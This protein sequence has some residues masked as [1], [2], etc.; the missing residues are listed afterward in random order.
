MR[1]YDRSVI[2]IDAGIDNGKVVLESEGALSP[3]AKP[4]ISKI[5]DIFRE[6]KPIYVDDENIVFSTWVPPVPGEVF[7]RLISAEISSI[8]RKRVPDQLSIGITSRCP[9]N[10]IHCGAADIIAKTELTVE[11]I[12]GAVSQS[13]EL[14]SYYISFDGGETM[15]RNDLTEMVKAVDK[16]KAIAAC[17]TSGFRLTEERA[18]D[19]KAAGLY[20]T[21]ISIDSPRE[22]EH[23]RVRGREGAF[24]DSLQGIKSTLEA[25]ILADMFVVVSPHNIDDLEDFYGLAENLGMHELSIYEIVAVGRWLEHEDEVISDSDVKMLGRFQK[26]KNRKSE[27]PRVT[28]LP[29]FMGPDQFG[30]FAGRRWMHVTPAGDVL[31]CAYTPLSFGNLVEEE[32]NVI[33]KRM[34]QHDAYRKNADFCR[35]RDQRFR[36]KYIHVIPKEAALPLRLDR[37]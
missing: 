31:P 19:L 5:N 17:F 28:A 13:I 29:Y 2:K 18:K 4:I 34:G 33:W 37:L 7:N 14:G 23:D 35:M 24:K 12:N 36:Q 30:C 1:V 32:L 6:E 26:E 22:E 15:M 16:S 9:N 3:I 11:Q 27:G 25:G 10:C 8:L 21:H 20:A